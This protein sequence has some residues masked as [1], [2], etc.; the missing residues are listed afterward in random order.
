MIKPLVRADNQWSHPGAYTP[1]S[2]WGH[3]WVWGHVSEKLVL[4]L[5]LGLAT[6]SRF[7]G[8]QESGLQVQ[9]VLRALPLE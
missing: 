7:Q 3:A 5:A 2:D 4:R 1:F 9:V 6:K 8:G